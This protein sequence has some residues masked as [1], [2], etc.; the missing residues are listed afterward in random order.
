[1]P[2]DK[3]Q[4]A[5]RDNQ[6]IADDNQ[7]SGVVNREDIPNQAANKEPAEGSR[8]HAVGAEQGGGISNRPLDEEKDNQARV[9]ARGDSKDGSHA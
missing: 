5:Q 9:P 7:Q 2:Q 3:T 4:Q 1:M 8:E 6:Q